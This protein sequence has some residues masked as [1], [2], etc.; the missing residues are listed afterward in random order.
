MIIKQTKKIIPILLVILLC[1]IFPLNTYK[2]LAVPVHEEIGD[3]GGTEDIE[4]TLENA[5]ERLAEFAESFASSKGGSC[6]Y[7]QNTSARAATYNISPNSSGL[8]QFDCVGWVS[9][10]I[11]WALGLDCESAS[12]GS[13]GFVTPQSRVKDPAHFIEIQ[14][15]G[16]ARRGDILI[17][18]YGTPYGNH[19][20]IY[21]GNQQIVDCCNRSY[22]VKIDTMTNWKP[23]WQD[24]PFQSFATL[25]S[26]DG[27]NFGD[28]PDGT[29]INNIPAGTLTATE[30][31][32]DEIIDRMEFDGMPP[33]VSYDG[34]HSLM[35]YIDKITK[36]FDYLIGIM[37][38][39]IKVAVVGVI[40]GIQSIITNAL[41]FLGG[42]NST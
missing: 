13:G 10:A 38:N 12:S 9:Y 7:T 14:G 41:D 11:H 33:D 24:G 15:V 27:V 28:L 2:V 37:F 20:A 36:A 19:V 1:M 16:S 3:E 4:V 35:Y 21:L 8:F 30:V 22:A 29:D 32:L 23:S 17:A 5:R 6:V 25:I 40:D 31:D 26:L 18:N 42:T 39:G 34:G